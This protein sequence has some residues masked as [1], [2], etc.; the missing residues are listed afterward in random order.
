VKKARKTLKKR[1]EGTDFELFM[2]DLL[3][4]N[5]FLG[6]ISVKYGGLFATNHNFAA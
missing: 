4:I 6:V 2:K 5:G 1:G 3:K